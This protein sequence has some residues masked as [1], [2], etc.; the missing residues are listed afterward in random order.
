MGFGVVADHC[1]DRFVEE[2]FEKFRK[3]TRKQPF[4]WE[5]GAHNFPE[6]ARS[7][8][9]RRARLTNKKGSLNRQLTD[10]EHG[11]SRRRKRD[12]EY[13]APLCFLYFNNQPEGYGIAQF[14]ANGRVL[15]VGEKPDVRKRNCIVVGRYFYGGQVVPLEIIK[16]Q[17]GAYLDEYDI[18]RFEDL[19]GRSTPRG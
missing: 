3:K 13:T 7:P 16:V 19:Y 9:T 17:S 12:F 18:V 6:G 5:Y 14:D 11:Y 2:G 10:E 4:L 15:S 8:S 1:G